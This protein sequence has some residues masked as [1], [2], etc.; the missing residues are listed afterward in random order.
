MTNEPDYFYM[1]CTRNPKLMDI[2][3]KVGGYTK[4]IFCSTTMEIGDVNH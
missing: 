3:L 1:P 4:L 2:F